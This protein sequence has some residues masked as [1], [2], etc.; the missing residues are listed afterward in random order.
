MPSSNTWETDVTAE[1]KKAQE[2][3]NA[4]IASLAPPSDRMS[5]DNDANNALLEKEAADDAAAAEKADS[6]EKPAEDAA[7]PV[8]E[9]PIFAATQVSQGEEVL[10]DPAPLDPSAAEP[11][12]TAGE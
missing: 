9:T 3:T 6:E 1:L 10:P 4:Y 11:V 2:I 7:E 8:E 12:A 5:D